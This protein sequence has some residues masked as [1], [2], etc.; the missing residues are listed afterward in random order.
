MTKVIQYSATVPYSPQ[1]MFDLVNDVEAYPQYMKGCADAK[2][3]Q[4]GEDWLMARLSLGTSGVHHSFTT[5][6]H[7]QAPSQM[8]VS[9]VEGPFKVF[10][11]LWTFKPTQG[12]GCEVSFRLEYE[13]SNFLL[14]L[15]AGKLMQHMAGEQVDALCLRAKQLYGNNS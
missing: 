8:V 13:F 9:L 5:R 14:A 3:L 4:R 15:A 12:A 10:K 2:V 11:G 6:N 1:Q 7:W